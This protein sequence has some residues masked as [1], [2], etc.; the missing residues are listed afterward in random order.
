MLKIA[1]YTRYK[2]ARCKIQEQDAIAK[3]KNQMQDA[4]DLARVT[5][6]KETVTIT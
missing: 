5:E 4:D 6:E 3:G 2:I 1:I